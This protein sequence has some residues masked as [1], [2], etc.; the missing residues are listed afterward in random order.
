[1]TATASITVTVSNGTSAG[2]TASITYPGAGATVKGNQSIG[3]STTAPW[4]KS[5]TFTL[6]VDDQ[7]VTS[8]I[9]TATTLWYTLDTTR[10]AS[11]AHTLTLAVTFNGATATATRTITFANGGTTP[12]P[13]PLSAAFS[14][15]A[16]GSTVSGTVTV[17]MS[18]AG[19]A[20]GTRTFGV[21]FGG[22]SS[23]A[24]VTVTSSGTT[25]SFAWNT[26]TT[27]NGSYTL[28]LT[29]TDSAGATASATRAVTVSNGTAPPP[30][31]PSSGFT[32][33]ITYPANNATVGGNQSVGMSTS[34]AWGT[35]KTWTLAVD[36]HVLTTQS[37]S[38][39]STLWYTWNTT[40]VANGTHTL[41]V[42]VTT[43]GGTAA[44]SIAVTVKN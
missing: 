4:G 6:S 42:T 8:Q 23:V 36:G 30:P 3:M 12:A 9:L 26:T 29:V 15:P 38:T 10:F 32:A 18:S 19:G 41:T 37:V 34:A 24:P 25:A 17:G 31:P 5:K 44:S 33:S 35:A 28:T 20:S 16:G 27:T 22:P 1:M 7:V 11:G 14:T 40:G 2:F 21:S 39:G 13:G 43:G